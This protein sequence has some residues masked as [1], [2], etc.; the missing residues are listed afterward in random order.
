MAHAVTF[1]AGCAAQ[2]GSVVAAATPAAG[3]ADKRDTLAR[4]VA[5]CVRAGEACLAHCIASLS[6]GS[7]MMA[8]CAAKVRVMLGICRAVQVL[9]TTD[10]PH[11]VALAKIC[12]ATCT[13]C[14]DTC[15][16]HAG[17]HAVC[18]DCEKA[19]RVASSAA[20]ALAA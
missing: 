13:E 5:E 1:V 17:H 12:A 18:G 16:A 20:A 4:A 6:T 10:S 14:A 8:D 19:C 9:A 3:G 15:A 2:G 7:T 11:L